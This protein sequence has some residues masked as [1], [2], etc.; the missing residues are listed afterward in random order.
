[1]RAANFTHVLT[2]GD[3]RD[4]SLEQLLVDV[5]VVTTDNGERVYIGDGGDYSVKV[6]DLR[7]GEFI[8]SIGSEG[9]APGEFRDISALHINASGHLVVFDGSN[10]RV[11]IFASD[12]SLIDTR[13]LDLG[14]GV[15]L[16]S[17]KQ[18]SNGLH[19]SLYAP[20]SIDETSH[21][22]H[23]LNRDLTSELS[24]FG[25][26]QTHGNTADGFFLRSFR[27]EP[28]SYWLNS[29]GQLTYV[30]HLYRGRLF[31]Y[32]LEPAGWMPE[33]P[34][35]RGMEIPDGAFR[36]V[37]PGYFKTSQF[38]HGEMGTT[39][40]FAGG[41]LSAVL[42]SISQ[43]VYALRDGRLVHFSFQYVGDGY[44][45]F[46]EVFAEDGRLIKFAAI[47]KIVGGEEI[48]L[49][50]RVRLMWKDNRDRFYLLDKRHAP[51][52]HVVDLSFQ[53]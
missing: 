39:L 53:P 22:F 5:E 14:A 36:R 38:S 42:L 29:E 8:R 13:T 19:L 18:L 16:K 21:V 49:D 12:G 10:D 31:Q 52:L 44:R 26:I 15:E 17:L 48:V 24:S 33:E 47:E 40:H 32:R 6:I 7:T 23:V 41:K 46:V 34:A 28:G 11:S 37:D 45:H 27:G 20:L 50:E 3:D 25:E 1:M 4:L 43:G 2:Y 51:I 35:I 9:S 30:P